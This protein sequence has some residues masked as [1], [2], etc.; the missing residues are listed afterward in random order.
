MLGVLVD[1]SVNLQNN[2]TFLQQRGFQFFFFFLLGTN[3]GC[4]G[5]QLIYFLVLFLKEASLPKSNYEENVGDN[6][7]TSV[8]GSWWKG[9]QWDTSPV[10]KQYGSVFTLVRPELRLLKLQQT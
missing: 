8:S 1:L 9:Y 5:F 3:P 7:H 2:E 10:R 4:T 6:G